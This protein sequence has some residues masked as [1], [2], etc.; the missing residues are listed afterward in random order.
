MKFITFEGGEGSGKTTQAKLLLQS[1]KELGK[2]AIYTREPGGTE[3]AEIIR[4]LITSEKSPKWSPIAELLLINAARYEHARHV[5]TPAIEQGKTVLCD[6]FVDSTMAYQGFGH[7]IGRKLPA[8]IHNFTMHGLSPELTFI[9]DINPT[10]GLARVKA[11]HR[12]NFEKL[13]LDFHERVRRGFQEI[14][15]LATERCVLISASKSVTDIHKIIIET[16]NE[17]SNLGLKVAEFSSAI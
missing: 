6:R 17:R 16:I 11:E 9:L 3:S 10:D 12:N 4:D 1:F 15:E 7:K 5:I 14:A 2:E 8:I 13:S